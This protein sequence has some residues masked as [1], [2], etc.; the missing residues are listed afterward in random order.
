MNGSGPRLLVNVQLTSRLVVTH[1]TDFQRNMHQVG[2]DSGVWH[3]GNYKTK[4]VRRLQPQLMERR[5]PYERA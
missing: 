4:V 1:H 2:Q 3:C 5:G